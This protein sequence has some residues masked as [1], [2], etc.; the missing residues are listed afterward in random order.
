[1]EGL[2]CAALEGLITCA[3]KTKVVFVCYQS[4]PREPVLE[5]TKTIVL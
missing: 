1:M 2:T 5:K 3:G 4:Y